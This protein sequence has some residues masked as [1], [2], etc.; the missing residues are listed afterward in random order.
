MPPWV[1]IING[2]AYEAHVSFIHHVDRDAMQRGVTSGEC[3]AEACSASRVK[4]SM[5]S[6]GGEAP[7]GQNNPPV[8]N[9][10]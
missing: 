5:G 7:G 2:T 3:G 9:T 4:S 10:N 8:R 1:C 6:D